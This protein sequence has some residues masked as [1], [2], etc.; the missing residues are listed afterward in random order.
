[1]LY[2]VFSGQKPPVPDDM[3]PSYRAVLAQCWATDPSARPKFHEV[4]PQLCEM[5]DAIRTQS[6]PLF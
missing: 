1:V 6:A 2:K 4:L 5:L 3:P